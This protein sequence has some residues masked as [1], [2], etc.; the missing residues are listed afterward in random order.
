MNERCPEGRIN[1]KTSLACVAAGMDEEPVTGVPGKRVV[2][3]AK[4]EARD[5]TPPAL[6]TA[7]RPHVVDAERSTAAPR[8]TRDKGIGMSVD[9]DAS[10]ERLSVPMWAGFTH[11]FTGVG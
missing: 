6:E 7:E 10:M 8:A 3:I 5:D 2:D 11:N 9:V 4:G 1:S